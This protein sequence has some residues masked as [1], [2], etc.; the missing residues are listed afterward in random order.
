VWQKDCLK[1]QHATE[2]QP[3]STIN[4]AR[5]PNDSLPEKVEATETSCPI[6]VCPPTNAVRVTP[7]SHQFGSHQFC[8]I[9]IETWM[10]N[11]KTCPLC[12]KVIS[13]AMQLTTGKSLLFT[14]DRYHPVDRIKCQGTE[15][16]ETVVRQGWLIHCNREYTARRRRKAWYSA[17]IKADRVEYFALNYIHTLIAVFDGAP[18]RLSANERL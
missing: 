8:Y 12:R 4:T 9:C 16:L 13:I 2:S 18:G 3:T 7:C 15:S 11:S 1:F 6:C 5:K 17:K 10:D 14:T